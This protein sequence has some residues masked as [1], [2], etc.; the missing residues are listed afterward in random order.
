MES[1]VGNNWQFVVY[2]GLSEG[3]IGVMCP[4]LF[5]AS[6]NSSCILDKLEY[7]DVTL[8]YSRLDECKN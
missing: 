7:C 4:N 3:R 8:V 1:F 5:G 2:P 6:K